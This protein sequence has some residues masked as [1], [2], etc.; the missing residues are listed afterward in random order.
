M[1]GG[2]ERVEARNDLGLKTPFGQTVDDTGLHWGTVAQTPHP[3]SRNGYP[4]ICQSVR[5]ISVDA[6]ANDGN[7][8]RTAWSNNLGS[9]IIAS[10]PRMAAD[11][12]LM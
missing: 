1:T 8:Q 12:G 6:E 4:S 3:A 11:V 7:S 10:R 5:L 2:F 9:R